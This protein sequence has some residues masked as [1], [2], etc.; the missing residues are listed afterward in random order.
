MNL[1]PTLG[2]SCS[3]P[4]A[5]NLITLFLASLHTTLLFF[6]LLI[7]HFDS[8]FALILIFFY[9]RFFSLLW[10]P[11]QTLQTFS[12][13]TFCTREWNFL[14]LL[15]TRGHSTNLCNLVRSWDEF[16]PLFHANK[17]KNTELS[18]IF[19]YFAR[20]FALLRE[21]VDGNCISK[22]YELL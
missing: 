7:H 15:A 12:F 14:L 3:F 17:Q 10:G 16:T 1:A 21:F 22:L 8:I 13:A 9:F 4:F 5:F 11:R 19:Q 6:G 18:T 20:I 2:L